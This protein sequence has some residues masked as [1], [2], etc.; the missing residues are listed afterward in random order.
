MNLDQYLERLFE[1]SGGFY[2]LLVVIALQL[3]AVAGIGVTVILVQINAEFTFDQLVSGILFFSSLLILGGTILFGFAHI[4]TRAA[5]SQLSLN[6]QERRFTSGDDKELKA[7]KE[8]TS[9]AWRYGFSSIIVAVFVEILPLLLFL[10]Y[11]NNASQDQLLY[12]L[13]GGGIASISIIS[14]TV[15][16][17]DALL[18]PAR[19]KLV[20]SEFETQLSGAGG[21]NIRT[22][23]QAI[24]LSLILLAI[25]LIGPIGY[26]QTVT[27]LYREIGSTDVFLALQRQIIIASIIALSLGFVLVYLLVN[28][29][30]QPVNALI[31]TFA[32]V[33]K[34]DLNQRVEITSTDEIGELSIYFNRMIS[35]L[36]ELQKDLE[37][38][39]EQRTSHLKAINEIGRVAASI[40]EPEELI[41]RVVNL[42]TDEFGYYY[43]ALFIIDQEGR[44]AELRD[45]TGEAGKVLRQSKHRLEINE[46]SMVGRGIITKQAQVAQD[47]GEK[48]IRF[49]NPLLPYTR[50]EIALPLMVADQVMGAL[51]VQS[52]QEAA[53]GEQDIDTLQNMANQ[54]AVALE[55]ARLFQEAHQSIQELQTIQKN[56]LRQSWNVSNFPEGE[57]VLAIGDEPDGTGG[58]IN[59]FPISLRDETIGE[60]SITSTHE[61]SPEETNWIQAI[62]I[63]AAL[64]LENARLLEESQNLAMR[65][66]FVTEITNKIWS[67]N[68]VDGILQVSLRELGQILDASEATIELNLDEEE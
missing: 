56:Y 3:V 66:R 19:K 57:I 49:N 62:I 14:L 35:R 48:S 11:F 21:F 54:V 59:S 30:S 38:Q 27:V 40:L 39:V 7:W 51:D 28:A 22:K 5:R 52:T 61:L 15:L 50:S 42:I 44:Y 20:P 64:A 41:A 23:F 67:A 47:I 17:L 46:K 43:S 10:N 4:S 34:G 29:I 37:H 2:V 13:F 65:E 32:G 12:T 53:F 9:I 16:A 18:I 24:V 8:I 55:N 33:E 25:L 60:I 58:H 68:T 63:Q 45:A 36:A 1:R 31:K 6:A 26:H